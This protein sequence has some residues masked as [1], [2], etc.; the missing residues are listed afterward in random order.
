MGFNGGAESVSEFEFEFEFELESE[1]EPDSRWAIASS[2]FDNKSKSWASPD[3]AADPEP[4]K[5]KKVAIRRN[6]F[7]DF[8]STY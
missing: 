5:L 7:T 6:I 3:L 4:C 8:T 1:L 2:I